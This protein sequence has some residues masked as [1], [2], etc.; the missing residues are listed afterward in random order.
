MVRRSL[1]SRLFSRFREDGRAGS[2]SSATRA[3]T[4]SA[5]ELRAS[6]SGA[7]AGEAAARGAASQVERTP[8]VRSATAVAER[9]LG[10]REAGS[11]AASPKATSSPPS[12]ASTR[13]KVGESVERSADAS[14]NSDPGAAAA[15]SERKNSVPVIES[16]E[17]E[18]VDGKPVE[19]AVDGTERNSF[20]SDARPVK[21]VKSTKLE[22]RE[23]LSMKITDGLGSLSGLLS[24]IDSKMVAHQQTAQ[25][26][27]QRLEALPPLLQQIAS[28]QR[29]QTEVLQTLRRAQEAQRAALADQTEGLTAIP[30][31]V[32]GLGE[33]VKSLGSRVEQQTA[34]SDSVR[35]SVEG[36]TKGVRSLA[37]GAQRANQTLVFEFRRAQDEHRRRLEE[38]A[39][40]ERKTGLW[41]AALGVVVVV[42]LV[43]IL[44]RITG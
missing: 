33:L 25:R 12:V 26:I 43:V 9:P 31:S 35:T 8:E 22:S 28:G 44:F 42:C 36:V 38:L 18:R 24:D 23:E 17:V 41:V 30:A 3:P 21:E 27:A 2:S 1:I 6:S 39:D 34:S 4:V 11:G 14:N 10:G 32:E 13:G 37:D 19:G 15:A 7:A 20:D 5:A 16:V 40:R 29:E